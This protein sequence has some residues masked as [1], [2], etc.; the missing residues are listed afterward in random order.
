MGPKMMQNGVPFS[1]T[2]AFPKICICRRRGT[3]LWPRFWLIKFQ[4]HVFSIVFSTI[5]DMC[6]AS[7]DLN[8][9]WLLRLLIGLIC[10]PSSTQNDPAN[11][12]PQVFANLFHFG[13]F[14][15]SLLVSIFLL[16]CSFGVP[17]QGPDYCYKMFLNLI[18]FGTPF[19]S[20][21]GS[22]LSA[23]FALEVVLEIVS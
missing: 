1:M 22:F 11:G 3:N 15:A 13:C 21:L 9:C 6:H 23:I 17:N 10:Y 2:F 4:K 5:F 14:L 7:V 19:G 18:H 16:F 20:I 8:F 12:L